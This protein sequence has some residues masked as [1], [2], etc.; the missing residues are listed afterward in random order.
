M[1][2]IL[3]GFDDD[4]HH[5]VAEGVDDPAAQDDRLGVEDIDQIGHGNAGVFGGVLDDFLDQFVAFANGLAQ[6]AAAQIGQIRSQH[7]R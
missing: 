7:V 4:G 5:F 2:V 1:D 6:I 3:G